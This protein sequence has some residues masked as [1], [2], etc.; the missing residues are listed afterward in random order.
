M[1]R[2]MV[3]NGARNII[4]VS[5]GGSATGKVKE[6]MVDLAAVGANVV[7]RR[8]DVSNSDS[9]HNLVAN[10]LVG[11]PQVRGIIHGAMLLHVSFCLISS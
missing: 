2:W 7:M 3:N 10:E 5:R 11:M 8:C 9:V 4:L 6:L 1:A